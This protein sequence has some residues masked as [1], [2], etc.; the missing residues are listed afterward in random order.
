ML[1][2][3]AL[4]WYITNS[5]R[6]FGLLFLQDLKS[7]NIL[8]DNNWRV[9]ITDFG[10]SQMRFRTLVSHAGVGAGS[11]HWMAPEMLRCENLDEKA[12]VYSYGVVLWEILTGRMPWEDLNPMQVVGAVGFRGRTLPVPE[13]GDPVLLELFKTCCQH[14]PINRPSFT[15]ILEKFSTCYGRDTFSQQSCRALPSCGL[16]PSEDSVDKGGVLDTSNVVG[17]NEQNNVKGH[18][19]IQETQPRIIEVLSSDSEKLASGTKMY[20]KMEPGD[21]S[22]QNVGMEDG[23][24]LPSAENRHSGG[25]KEPLMPFS[26]FALQSSDPFEGSC[27]DHQENTEDGGPTKAVPG[28]PEEVPQLSIDSYVES[29]SVESRG[30]NVGEHASVGYLST[31]PENDQASKSPFA[32]YAMVPFEHDKADSLDIL[33]SSTNES[34][35][36]APYSFAERVPKSPGIASQQ[37]EIAFPL[38]TKEAPLLP[39]TSNSVAML[40]N[41]RSIGLPI[42]PFA[43][44]ASVPI[45]PVRTHSSDS[46]SQLSRTDE[47]VS[48]E[49]KIKVAEIDTSGAE[50]DFTADDSLDEAH[51]QFLDDPESTWEHH[52][53]SD[54]LNECHVER[55]V[56]G[57]SAGCSGSFGT[58]STARNFGLGESHKG[59]PS[60]SGC[61]IPPVIFTQEPSKAILSGVFNGKRKPTTRKKKSESLISR[62]RC[63]AGHVW[64]DS[65]SATESCRLEDDSENESDQCVTSNTSSFPN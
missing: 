19:P 28:Q 22:I 34:T 63:I 37:A 62:F 51:D 27:A 10:L 50:Q 44:Y 61:T 39:C 6:A 15:N 8:V 14:D 13:A 5:K 30:R 26:P 23:T 24:C 35:M 53:S 59:P 65:S 20:Q 31:D 11:P 55:N 9:K 64:R 52:C 36:A 4:D 47:A 54:N 17:S 2:L 41:L 18:I 12:D 43:Q 3:K 57:P 16:S 32:T 21:K 29:I 25:V 45:E 38:E 1:L 46:S 7:P 42:S 33:R 58:V 49:W 40:P 60:S 48:C 56:A